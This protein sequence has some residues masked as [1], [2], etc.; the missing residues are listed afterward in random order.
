MGV[1][2]P[3]LR[4]RDVKMLRHPFYKKERAMS[5][6]VSRDFRSSGVRGDWH[7]GNPCFVLRISKR[8]ARM[9]SQEHPMPEDSIPV[10]LFNPGHVFAC[11]GFLVAADVLLGEAAGAFYW[12]DYAA[13]KFRLRS[14]V[15]VSPFSAAI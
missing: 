13:V 1:R 9:M 15:L 2:A 11:L 8:R 14:K 7:G 6:C 5:H 12:I 10:D 3:Q 4:R